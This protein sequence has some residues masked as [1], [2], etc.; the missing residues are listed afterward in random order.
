MVKI[1]LFQ[2]GG[3]G[4]ISDQGTR[5]HMLHGMAKKKKKVKIKKINKKMLRL[6]VLEDLV[7]GLV[8]HLHD[9]AHYNEIHRCCLEQAFPCK[10][11]V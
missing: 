5:S 7:F 3:A 6:C 9:S 2:C 11:Q 8:P 4:S 1:P 10:K